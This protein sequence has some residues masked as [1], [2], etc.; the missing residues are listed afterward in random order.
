MAETQ[1]EKLIRLRRD[2]RMAVTGDGLRLPDFSGDGEYKIADLRMRLAQLGAN[3]THAQSALA[4][5]GLDADP[6]IDAVAEE[7]RTELEEA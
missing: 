3:V 7:I 4:S 6:G 2:L 5:N 1:A